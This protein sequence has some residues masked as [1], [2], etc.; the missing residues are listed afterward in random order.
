MFPWFRYH[1]DVSGWGRK[2]VDPR[3]HSESSEYTLSSGLSPRG[4][5]AEE[6]A[7][8]DPEEAKRALAYNAGGRQ[9]DVTRNG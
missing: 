5:E 1:G 7:E 3:G 4:S 6:R 9:W 2:R 8:F